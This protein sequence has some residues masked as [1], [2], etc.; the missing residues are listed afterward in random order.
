MASHRLHFDPSVLHKHGPRIFIRISAPSSDIKEGS[1]V[2]LEFPEPFGI[3]AVI[4]TGASLT[5]V[6]P[7]VV[8]RC[9]LRPTGFAVVA[10]I[11]KKGLYRQ[12]A[13]CI[14]FPDTKLKTL[15]CIP[16]VACKI[17]QQPY[18]CL[19]G[20]DILRNWLLTYSG[21]GDVSIQELR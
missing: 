15:D 2:G 13:A 7:E 8:E 14:R 5:V 3:T 9:K 6:N 10:S 16:V 18:A 1:A 19:I 20:R 12:H 11:E 21:D 17:S 4:D